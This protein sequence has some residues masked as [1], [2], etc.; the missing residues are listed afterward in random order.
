M[1][2]QVNYIKVRV[3]LCYTTGDPEERHTCAFHDRVYTT[4][5]EIRSKVI[6]ALNESIGLHNWA[7]L[8]KELEPHSDSYFIDIWADG[9]DD[10]GK[11]F[12]IVRSLLKTCGL[13]PLY[14]GTVH[15]LLN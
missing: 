5:E 8:L 2:S 4:E 6:L 13:H 15:Q 10:Y 1:I 7:I 3:G 14:R 9:Y 11:V 12:C